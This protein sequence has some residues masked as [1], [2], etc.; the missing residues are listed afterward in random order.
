MSK[1]ILSCSA[2]QT[3]SG[4]RVLHHCEVSPCFV[5]FLEECVCVLR[6]LTPVSLEAMRIQQ[7]KRGSQA[8]N[9]I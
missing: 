2:L 9:A 6:E 8:H 7:K 3:E 5:K 1:F 4:S